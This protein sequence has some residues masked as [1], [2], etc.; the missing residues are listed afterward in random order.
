MVLEAHTATCF[1]SVFGHG[2]ALGIN[3]SQTSGGKRGGTADVRTT[4]FAS[5]IYPGIN[6]AVTAR[7][8]LREIAIRTSA[9]LALQR[10]PNPS[11]IPVVVLIVQSEQRQ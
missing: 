2:N 6:G 4:R 5:C 9:R 3:S 1:T 11:Y 10:S 7:Q 8:S